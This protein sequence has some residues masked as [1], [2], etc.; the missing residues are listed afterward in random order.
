MSNIENQGANDAMQNKNMMDDPNWTAED[1]KKYQA[2][3][4][5]PTQRTRRTASNSRPPEF[6]ASGVLARR[7]LP[8]GTRAIVFAGFFAAAPAPLAI[9]N[10]FVGQWKVGKGA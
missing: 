3:Y 5:T 10:P 9:V 7:P 4:T 8:R 6:R 2:A 1:R